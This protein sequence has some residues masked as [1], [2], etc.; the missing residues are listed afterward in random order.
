MYSR[1]D[2]HRFIMYVEELSDLPQKDEKPDDDYHMIAQSTFCRDGEKERKS[3]VKSIDECVD[4]IKSNFGDVPGFMYSKNENCDPCFSLDDDKLGPFGP[5]AVYKFGPADKMKNP[6]KVVCDDVGVDKE[7]KG[8]TW[9]EFKDYA[10]GML[11]TT[12]QL[13][14]Y[15][16]YEL[17]GKPF[18]DG[19][20]WT[21][22]Y[23]EETGM[24]N[25]VQMGNNP[26]WP[27][28]N[29]NEQKWGRPW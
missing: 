29:H 3:W 28:M 18:K 25:Y 15:I 21:A 4:H 20:F 16:K 11:P 17:D 24:E 27:G 9:G 10:K 6:P 7:G 8:F 22:T 5:D 26:W 12:R 1:A 23:D 2:L 14:D 19:D 13:Q